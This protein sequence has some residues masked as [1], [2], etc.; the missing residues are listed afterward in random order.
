MKVLLT[1]ATGFFG[2]AVLRALPESKHKIRCAIRT[3]TAD[4][5]A[6][7]A[8]RIEAVETQDLFAQDSAWWA[9]TCQDVDLVIHAAW[10][11]EPGKYLTSHRN[12]PCLSGTI[13]L[14]EGAL[15]AEV[16]RFVG[17]G[18][19]FE[20]DVSHGHLSI[21]T[22]LA[23]RTLYAATK[24]SAFLTLT[25]LFQG[26]DTAFTW[27]RLFYLF[28]ADEHQDRLVPYLHA[29]LKAG[30]VAELSSGRQIRDYMDV[31]AAVHLLLND[32]SRGIEGPSNICS[33]RARTVAD[34]ANEIADEYAR[35]DLLAFGAR[36]D[37]L[38]DPP[39]IV[40]VRPEYD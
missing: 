29:Q 9:R 6:S 7:L 11:A 26:T 33:G 27:A 1:G 23:P 5:L 17:I 16:S 10:Y 32:V 2:K 20:Y 3:G 22:P 38:V 21:E 34:L 19:C 40:G 24:A 13:A 31:D 18:T 30:R 39:T 37:N 8:H 35:R 28:G 36:A 15:A 4:R 12:L 25:N 14:A